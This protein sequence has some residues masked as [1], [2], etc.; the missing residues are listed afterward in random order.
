MDCSNKCSQIE[1]SGHAKF[2][3]YAKDTLKNVCACTHIHSHRHSLTYSHMYTHSVFTLT[4]IHMHIWD[5]PAII[6]ND[7]FN[8]GKMYSL[9]GNL[10]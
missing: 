3:K 4:Q 6:Q 5:D 9:V 10:I 2:L 1:L 7:I 8:S